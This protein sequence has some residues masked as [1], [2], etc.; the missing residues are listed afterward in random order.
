MY[1]DSKFGIMPSEEGERNKIFMKYS[2]HIEHWVLKAAKLVFDIDDSN[3]RLT[4]GNLGGR[5]ALKTV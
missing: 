4:S 2:A 5:V 1:F 3:A